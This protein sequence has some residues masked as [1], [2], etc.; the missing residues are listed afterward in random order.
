MPVTKAQQEKLLE[1]A[2]EKAGTSRPKLPL[3]DMNTSSDRLRMAS[4]L[5]GNA[6][7]AADK[8]N[9]AARS[10][11]NFFMAEWQSAIS[12]GVNPA[13]LQ[14]QAADRMMQASRPKTFGQGAH[15]T[16]EE[17]NGQ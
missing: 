16:S 15:S 7:D 1:E 8:A 2:L 10:A 17:S 5:L 3:P 4:V 13:T 6:L 11:L 12:A 9:M 14:S